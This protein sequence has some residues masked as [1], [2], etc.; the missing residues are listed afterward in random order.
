MR[1]FL[2][3]LSIGRGIILYGDTMIETMKKPKFYR[4]RIKAID[5]ERCRR[6]NSDKLGIDAYNRL[7][8]LE[9]YDYGRI[10]EN[11]YLYRLERPIKLRKHYI[12]MNYE[13]TDGQRCGSDFFLHC[14]KTKRSGFLQAV[15]GAGK[16]EMTYEVILAVL[17]RGQKSC[18][19]LPRVE[20]LKQVFKRYKKHFP[21]TIIK[22]LYAD[23]KDCGDAQ[24][25]IS[26][27]Q[28]LL[29]F[30]QEFDLLIV[31]EVDAF[32]L[33]DNEFLA[34]LIKKSLK[35]HGIILY[36]SA[37]ITKAFQNRIKIK[38]I[39]YHVISERYHRQPL[40]VPEFKQS[41]YFERNLLLFEFINRHLQENKR[42]LMFVPTIK[43]ARTYHNYFSSRYRCNYIC[44]ETRNKIDIIDDFQK[45]DYLFLITTTILER[46]ITFDNIDAIVLEANH[47]V[48]TK[49]A[50]IQIAGRVG[51]NRDNPTGEVIFFSKY[52]TAAMLKARQEII[53]MNKT[54]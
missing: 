35:P 44:S 45:G 40:P 17:N 36:M 49:E 26:T 23:F 1:G 31:D 39:D 32:P 54:L 22:K 52:K 2:K 51:R 46:G 10:T 5:G 28:Q 16:T 48:Y 3:E 8:C 47:Q 7:T 9:C 15:C 41:G 30:Y 43:K 18:I 14:L 25:I 33:R 34:R 29:K 11:N 20:A 12:D 27:P 50:L 13:L 19:V 38:E 37:T 53:A 24:L 42:F 6:C 21:K 4:E